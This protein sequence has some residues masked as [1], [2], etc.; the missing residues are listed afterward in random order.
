MC[1]NGGV[2]LT[3]SSGLIDEVEW[4]NLYSYIFVDLSRQ[5]NEASDNVARS[6]QVTYTNNS[7]VAMDISWFIFYSREICVNTSTGALVI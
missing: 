6:I 2:D 5:L 1:L 4:G 3:L 7:Q